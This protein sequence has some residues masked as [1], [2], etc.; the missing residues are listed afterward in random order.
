MEALTVMLFTPWSPHLNLAGRPR[1]QRRAYEE[2]IEAGALPRLIE[3]PTAPTKNPKSETLVSTPGDAEQST[4]RRRQ[5][6]TFQ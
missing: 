6:V 3:T 1:L 2:P 4:K 5:E